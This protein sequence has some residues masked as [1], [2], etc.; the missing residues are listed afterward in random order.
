M[1]Q[2][3]FLAEFR[4]I[5]EEQAPHGLYGLRQFLGG[6][7]AVLPLM[8]TY[9]GKN[10]ATH[11]PKRL[12]WQVYPYPEGFS[13]LIPGETRIDLKLRDYASTKVRQYGSRYVLDRV[14]GKKEEENGELLESLLPKMARAGRASIDDPV[15]C[16]C[17]LLMIAH[18]PSPKRLEALLGKATD[19][20]F[21]SRHE[22]KFFQSYWDDRY[23]R[24]ISS[25]VWLW[26]HEIRPS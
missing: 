5:D 8:Q 7:E 18:A 9:A 26:T 12:G 23:S 16:F 6:G 2:Q 20:S 11:V 19:E 1:W 22:L 3:E 13:L 4:K 24:G 10:A 14:H 21:L 17:G 15:K 25:A